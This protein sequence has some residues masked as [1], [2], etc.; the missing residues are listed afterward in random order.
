MVGTK[1]AISESG[2]DM[3]PMLMG[4]H[5][6]K[7]IQ[8]LKCNSDRKIPHHKNKEGTERDEINEYKN[9]CQSGG[10]FKDLNC[11]NMV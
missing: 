8:I 9:P 10:G 4:V 5:I 1:L 6:L 2:G 11:V 7:Q 3:M